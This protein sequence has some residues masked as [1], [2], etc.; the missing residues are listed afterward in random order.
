[1]IDLSY[2]MNGEGLLRQPKDLKTTEDLKRVSL[3]SRP[4]AQLEYVAARVVEFLQWEWFNSYLLWAEL[5]ADKEDFN[6]NLPT[7]GYEENNEP[8]YAEP[9][10]YTEEPTQPELLDVSILLNPISREQF[11]MD[12]TAIVARITVTVDGMIFDGDEISQGRMDR[13]S[14]VME[15]QS[16]ESMPWTLTDN[17][18]VEVTY[19]QLDTAVFLSGVKQSSVWA[20]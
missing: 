4:T 19:T 5:E 18:V 16:I 17:T 3:K 2:F 14:R 13:A 20:Q 7:I 6:R 15:K 8:I 10:E 11:K 1:M 9:I 12:R